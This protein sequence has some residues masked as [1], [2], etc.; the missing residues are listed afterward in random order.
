MSVN[1]ILVEATECVRILIMDLHAPVTWDIL[2][3]PATKILI[4]VSKTPARTAEHAWVRLTLFKP[5]EILVV[6][7]P[8]RLKC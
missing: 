7:L 4:S 1:P 6:L 8:Q 2:E 5:L 3:K